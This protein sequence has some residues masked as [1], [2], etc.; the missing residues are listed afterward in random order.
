MNYF[1]FHLLSFRIFIFGEFL[2]R[3]V[4][5]QINHVESIF[6]YLV[7]QSER[8]G[9]CQNVF[10]HLEKKNDNFVND[11]ANGV[12]GID[13]CAVMKLCVRV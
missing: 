3:R 2:R 6:F 13:F 7:P 8:D 1:F 12:L 4:C 9:M 5:V 11:T 10:Q